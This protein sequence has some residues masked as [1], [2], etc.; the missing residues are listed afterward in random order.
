MEVDST[1]GVYLV[2]AHVGLGAPHWDQYARAAFL[3]MTRGTGRKHLVR[4]TLESIAYQVY[5]VME[6]MAKDAGVEIP[7]LRVD[8]GASA[9]NFV[10]QFQ[11]D[12][13]GKEVL[14]PVCVET[15]ALGAAYLAGLA[16][17]YWANQDEIVSNWQVD[18]KFEP[19]MGKAEVDKLLAGWQKAVSRA[20]KW[21]DA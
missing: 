6:A 18:R 12:I 5:D 1:G 14:R 21:E 4:A 17:G 10:M 7:S 9:N 8:G 3:G 20:L 19:K 2:P 15:T 13:M 16:V 11:S